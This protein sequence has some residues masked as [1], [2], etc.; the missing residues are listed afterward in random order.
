MSQ[1]KVDIQNIYT[2]WKKKFYVNKELASYFSNHHANTK[3]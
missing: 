2:I 3:S 1:N